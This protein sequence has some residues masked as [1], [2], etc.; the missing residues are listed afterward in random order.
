MRTRAARPKRTQGQRLDQR[1]SS[2]KSKRSLTLS[3]K[4]LSASPS[5]SSPFPF[6]AR[7]VVLVRPEPFARRTLK[8]T[9]RTAHL[10]LGGVDLDLAVEDDVLP[11][12]RADVPQQV[13]VE[14]EIGRYGQAQNLPGLP[15]GE[16]QGQARARVHLVVDL[17]GADASPLPA[18]DGPRPGVELLDL[19]QAPPHLRPRF[20]LGHVL[21][22]EFR[23]ERAA[24]APGWRRRSGSRPGSG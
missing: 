4:S 9:P 15:A 7:G 12:D 21:Q 17:A 5:G 13:G 3:L 20:R 11:L 18:V 8:Y 19:E 10:E 24:E 1:S 16:D 22:H 6:G 14:R 2:L 23:L